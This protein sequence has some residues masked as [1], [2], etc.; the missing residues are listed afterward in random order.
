M[1]LK[2][3]PQNFFSLN[4]VKNN[5]KH[6]VIGRAFSSILAFVVALVIIRELEVV[7]YAYYTTL[8]G[9]L[10][11]LMFLGSLGVDREL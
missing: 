3:K 7:D 6:F 5:F 9:L 8:T 2:N 4:R 1:N 10:I 11:V